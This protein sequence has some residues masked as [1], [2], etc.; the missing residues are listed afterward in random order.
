MS[1]PHGSD[2][3][4]TFYSYKGGTGRSMALANVACLLATQQ[5]QGKGILMID[6][7][8]EAPGLHRFFQGRLFRETPK[9]KNIGSAIDE[10]PG[11]IDLFLTFDQRTPNEA[12]R[13]DD[14]AAD[15]AI[16]CVES[17]DLDDYVVQTT[18]PY[19]SLMKAGCFDTGYSTR[20][21]TFHWENLFHRSPMLIQLFA[22]RL[23][24]VY[25]YVL[26]DSRTGLTDISGICTMLMPERLV[27]VFT[28]NRQSLTGV[29]DQVRRATQYRRQSDDLRPLLVFPLPS[30]IDISEPRR[31][32]AWRFGDKHA[33]IEGYQPLFENLLKE[34]YDLP[35]CDLSGYFDEI[36]V[37]HIPAYAYGEEI[38]A[39]IERSGDTLSITRS[40]GS[41]C[42]R[43]VNSDGPWS[44]VP[45]VANTAQIAEV[46]AQA[47]QST[48]AAQSH[49]L[50]AS[51]AR[52][53]ATLSA[54]ATVLLALM[55][56]ATMWLWQKGYTG[57]TLDQAVL[58]VQSLFVKIHLAPVMKTVSAG[59]FQQGDIHRHVDLAE[60]PMHEVTI[61]PFAIGAFE[62]TFE[63]YDR[64]AIARGQPLP[65]DQGWGRGNRPVINVSWDDA[66]AYTRWLS[67]M[68]GKGYRLP[69]EAEWEYAAR[70][71]GKGDVWAGTSDVS[72]LKDY[73]VFNRDGTQPVGVKK[74]NGVGLYDMS[75]NVW[76]WVEDC[77]H[78]DYTGAPPD[79]SA[80]LEAHG[81]NCGRRVVRGGSWDSKPEN[82]RASYR[83]RSYADYRFSYIG[84]RLAQDID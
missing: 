61:K 62:V 67:Q 66:L 51:K 47:A 63:E 45:E 56:G 25:R 82:L 24:R 33:D 9:S 2:A 84:F 12:P 41:L 43:V 4:I 15:L 55:T 76:E 11:L 29:L 59:T 48:R 26:I 34:I 23:A 69:T 49:A 27:V 40:Y 21:N 17:V 10:L 81:G 68:T 44:D 39:L 50:E 64:Y 20:V 22:E 6:W 75:G 31:R 36:Q 16:R 14:E 73:A 46:K 35:Q 79:G 71:E 42:E 58:K 52:R 83:F 8:L 13:T 72:H 77:W 70:S 7:D 65:Y 53:I 5:T 19:L 30:R 1:E 54:Y 28:P 78:E 37:P 74:S 57:Y 32:D 80:W 60:R 38:G 18:I 3:I